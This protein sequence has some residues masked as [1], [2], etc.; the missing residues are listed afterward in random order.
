MAENSGLRVYHASY[1]AIESID[2]EKC[3]KRNDFGQGFYATRDFQQARRFVKTAVKKAG[4]DT[5]FGFVNEYAIAGMDGLDVLRFSSANKEWLHCVCSHRRED[6]P[7]G[8]L[9]Q[10]KHYDVLSGKVANDDTMTVIGIYIAGG[11][12]EYGSADAIKIAISLLKQERFT[13][14]FCFKTEKA[15]KALRFTGSFKEPI[16]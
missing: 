12:G 8:E 7:T 14:Q 10:W 6:S 16:P 13:C 2:L 1:M 5:P 11:Y 15:V 9:E 4:L 3:R